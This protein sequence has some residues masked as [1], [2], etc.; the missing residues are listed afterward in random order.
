[1]PY[2]QTVS[3][4]LTASPFQ[5]IIG[6]EVRRLP[7]KQN[8]E[9]ERYPH[10]APISTL[11]FSGFSVKC[12]RMLHPFFSY[13]GSKYRL[14]KYYPVPVCDELIEPFA[15]SAGYALMYPEKQVTLYE[16]YDAI[17]ELWEYLI[18]VK[19]TEILALPLGPF[20]KEHPVENEVSC[21]PARTLMGFWLT[22]SQTNASRYPLSKSRGGNWSARKRAMLASQLHAIRHWKVERLSFEQIPNRK[23]TWFV[24]P[25]YEEAGS[26]YRFNKIDYSVLGKWCQERTGQVIVCEQNDAKWLDFKHLRDGR[27]ASN[28][29]Y[30]ELVWYNH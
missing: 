16:V 20:N 1:M 8:T 23:A 21:V 15:G 7:S 9:R 27:N 26:R 12:G 19:E 29:D 18:A 14:A 17:A 13:F 3:S 28:K 25:P 30:K 10:D 6:R 5:C 24:D 22:E 4:I 2:A 11:T